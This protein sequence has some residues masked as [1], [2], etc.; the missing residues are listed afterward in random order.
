MFHQRARTF[1]LFLMVSLILVTIISEPVR[2]PAGETY[3][4]S[5]SPSRIQEGSTTALS[6]AVTNASLFTSY[7]FAW[8]VTDPS[9]ASNTLS[10]TTNS[11]FSANFVQTVNYPQDFSA[12][13]AKYVGTYAVRVNETTPANKPNVAITSFQVALTDANTYQRTS[14]TSIQASSYLSGERITLNIAQAS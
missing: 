6:L 9:G 2:A 1:L 13:N 11:G 7:S 12:G 5:A 3:S 4:L 8:K 10:K 14:K